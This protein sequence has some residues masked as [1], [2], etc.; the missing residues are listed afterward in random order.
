MSA[1]CRGLDRGNTLIFLPGG[2]K[3]GYRIPHPLPKEKPHQKV[4]LF[5]LI[6]DSGGIRTI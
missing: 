1:A 4:W 2:K 5:F 3:N 6:S